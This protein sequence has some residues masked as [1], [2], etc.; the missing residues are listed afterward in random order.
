MAQY[1]LWKGRRSLWYTWSVITTSQGK[2]QVTNVYFWNLIISILKL[3]CITY[4]VSCCPCLLVFQ[5]DNT[6]YI[7]GSQ[8]RLRTLYSNSIKPLFVTITSEPISDSLNWVLVLNRE[9]NRTAKQASVLS[10]SKW[11]LINTNF[12]Q[13]ILVICLNKFGPQISSCCLHD[14]R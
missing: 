3:I 5:V 6:N 14:N 13:T 4:K 10:S 11:I 9:Q 12:D 2:W 8:E 7:S 1:V